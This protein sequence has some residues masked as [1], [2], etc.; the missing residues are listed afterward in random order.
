MDDCRFDLA[1]A[2]AD[3]LGGRISLARDACNMTVAD[4]ADMTGIDP[5][6]WSTWE[7]DRDA[8]AARHLEDIAASLHVSLS[9]LVTGRGN[10][11]RWRS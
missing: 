10:G 3:T 6:S 8:P 4:A 7:N 1:F 5:Q 9:W 11:P 2:T